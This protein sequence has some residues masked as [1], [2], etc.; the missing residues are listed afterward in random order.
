MGKVIHAAL[1]LKLM[2][3]PAEIRVPCT[4]P[5]ITKGTF[6]ANTPELPFAL[7]D[8]SHSCRL[9]FRIDPKS[10]VIVEAAPVGKLVLPMDLFERFDPLQ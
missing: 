7:S 9:E 4:E 5:I 10:L 3:G 1:V 2:L 8:V 6:C